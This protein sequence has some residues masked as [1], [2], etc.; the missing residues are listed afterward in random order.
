MDHDFWY[1][2]FIKCDVKDVL[3]LKLVC[4][5]SN[6]KIS[7]EHFWKIM[8]YKNFRDI[9]KLD[10]I[11]W[12]QYYKIRSIDYGTPVIINSKDDL[13]NKT[14]PNINKN[15]VLQ[16]VYNSWLD[17]IYILTTEYKLYTIF[18][19]DDDDDNIVTLKEHH[20]KITKLFLSRNHLLL[21][22]NDNNLY[23]YESRIKHELLAKNIINVFE[24]YSSNIICYYTDLIGTYCISVYNIITK[25]LDYQVLSYLKIGEYEFFINTKN[26]LWRRYKDD[27]YHYFN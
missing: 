27:K 3:K 10:N 26:Q 5:N 18:N 11:S 7:E 25:I 1:N 9:H 6:S 19:N 13:I 17:Y 15:N 22:D 23:S 12:L 24:S 14:E 16:C 4:K 2:V 8:M 20:T 21:I